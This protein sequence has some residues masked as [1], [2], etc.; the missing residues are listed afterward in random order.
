MVIFHELLSTPYQAL[1][2]VFGRSEAIARSAPTA[3]LLE[4][5]FGQVSIR[6][7]ALVEGHS[8]FPEHN[9]NSAACAS[10]GEK[11]EDILGLYG[12]MCLSSMTSCS[13]Y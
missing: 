6:K 8:Q 2:G 5:F 4:D 7:Y 11:A 13:F 12:I 10:T 3:F 9:R 1:R